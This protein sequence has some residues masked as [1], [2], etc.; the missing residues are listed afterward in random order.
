MTSKDKREFQLYLV[1]CTDKQV[2]GVYEK[3]RD[4]GRNDYATLAQ[5]EAA[6]RGVTL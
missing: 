2:I 4:A 3:E 5:I 6:K 1:N